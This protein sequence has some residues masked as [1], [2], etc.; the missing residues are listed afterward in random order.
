MKERVS[1]RWLWKSSS[2]LEQYRAHDVDFKVVSFNNFSREH[3][4]QHGTIEKYWAAKS[5]IISKSKDTV[6]VI[7]IDDPEIVK[8]MGLGEG[9]Q[10]TYSM[11]VNS[12]RHLRN[13]C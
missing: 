13:E 11:E 10:I 9:K 4:D 1:R 2:A 3:I 6:S 7:N 8:T 12:R 5:S